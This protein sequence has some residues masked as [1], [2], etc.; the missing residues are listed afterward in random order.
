LDQTIGYVVS[1]EVK[2]AQL[3]GDL[4]EPLS[5]LARGVTEIHFRQRRDA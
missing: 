2:E 3:V 5:Q 4:A 1:G